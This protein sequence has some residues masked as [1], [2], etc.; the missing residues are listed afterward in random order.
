MKNTNIL[1]VTDYSAPYEGNFIESLKF[2]EE[3]MKVNGNKVV[4]YIKSKMH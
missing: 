2:L 3:K 4:W 1:I